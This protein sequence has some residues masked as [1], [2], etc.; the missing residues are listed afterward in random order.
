MACRGDWDAIVKFVPGNRSCY[1]A[2]PGFG[3]G[4]CQDEAMGLRFKGC[5]LGEAINADNSVLVS[6]LPTCRPLTEK[7]VDVIHSS[8][9]PNLSLF[10]Y[11][12]VVPYKEV[13]ASILRG[14]CNFPDLQDSTGVVIL[15]YQITCC[16]CRI[17]CS[18]RYMI[19]LM[20]VFELCHSRRLPCNYGR[21]DFRAHFNPITR[22]VHKTSWDA[23]YR[24][25][26]RKV[27]AACQ[28]SRCV[29]HRF[30]SAKRV[31]NKGSMCGSRRWAFL[32]M[33]TSD[34]PTG[35]GILI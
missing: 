11:P 32:N 9:K 31:L 21:Q 20:D 16:C 30:E 26:S 27:G 2:L 19:N 12:Q 23:N 34:I 10:F 22:P 7:C 24:V 25:G 8:R 13:L 18:S 6:G 5:G 15:S 4:M 1:A 3:L 29:P 28:A 17:C 14:F 33:S 35:S